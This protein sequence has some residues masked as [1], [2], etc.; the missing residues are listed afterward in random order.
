MVNKGKAPV[1]IGG[2]LIRNTIGRTYYFPKG[3]V[4]AAGRAIKVHT[5]AGNN[6]AT[7]LY[8][9]YQFKPVFD[10]RDQITLVDD[11]DVDVSKLTTP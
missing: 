5:G 8:W 7:D 1:R 3:T 11:S 9:N 2:W 6:S 10:H 4:I